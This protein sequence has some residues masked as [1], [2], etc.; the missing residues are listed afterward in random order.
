MAVKT[1]NNLHWFF[2]FSFFG[3]LFYEFAPL[4]KEAITDAY[5]KH[6]LARE[7]E[8][9]HGALV[10]ARE[11][12]LRSGQP[13]SVNI[14]PTGWTVEGG[15]LTHLSGKWGNGVT[16]GTNI[17]A[18]RVIFDTKKLDTL[19]HMHEV[20]IV[21]DAQRIYTIFFDKTGQPLIEFDDF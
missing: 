9:Y 20:T 1:E 19:A 3:L 21:S 10:A 11:A 2:A 16:I 8:K 18:G 5:H 4:A 17:P 12:A 6:E 14:G 13:V 7:A 15:E